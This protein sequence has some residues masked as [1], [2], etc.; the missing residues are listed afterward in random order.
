MEKI[1]C[2][3]DIQKLMEQICNILKS[4]RAKKVL[5]VCGESIKKNNLYL[6]LEKLSK[7]G[8]YEFTYFSDFEPNPIIQ[9]AYKGC[10]VFKKKECDFLMAI[11]GGSAIDVAKIVLLLLHK[12]YSIDEILNRK[13][14]EE[15]NLFHSIPFLAIPT[16]AGTGSEAT[17]FAVAYLNHTKVSVEHPRLKPQYT[18]LAPYL[19]KSLPGYQRRATMLDAFCHAVEAYWSVNA[20]AESR[21]YSKLSLHFFTA[22]YQSYLDNEPDGNY[23]MLLAA[24]YAGS[25]IHIA[26]TTAAHALAYILTDQYDIPHGFAVGMCLLPVWKFLLQDKSQHITSILNEI[27]KCLNKESAL[28][29]YQVFERI[30]KDIGIKKLSRREAHDL[31]RLVC[32]VNYERLSN[33]PLQL[34]KDDIKNIYDSMLISI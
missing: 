8:K 30:W 5:V 16:T 25:A 11:G 27:A 4:T 15:K 24:H 20:T 7:E 23:S 21:E 12:E 17:Q 18:I 26:K 28:E 3:F 34:R 22:G 29:G 6:S 1:N 32:S 33:F 31:D 13:Y 10:E 14:R 9:S 2:C 19:L